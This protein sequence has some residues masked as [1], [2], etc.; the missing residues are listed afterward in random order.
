MKQ[1]RKRNEKEEKKNDS[2]KEKPSVKVQYWHV[3][4]YLSLGV[5]DELKF[6]KL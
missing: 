6:T 5:S 1:E 4:T 3:L 2:G